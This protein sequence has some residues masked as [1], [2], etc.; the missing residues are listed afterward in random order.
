MILVDTS[1]W[2]DHFRRGDAL[3]SE[4]LGKRQVSCHPWVIGE[5]ALGALVQRDEILHLLTALPQAVV[6][7][8][9]EVLQFVDRHALARTGIGYVDAQLLAASLLTPETLL[10]TRDARLVRQAIRLGVAAPA[11]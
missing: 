6:A 7:D 11:A 4:R 2:I 3:L 10:W 5:L 9:D 8:P 1:I